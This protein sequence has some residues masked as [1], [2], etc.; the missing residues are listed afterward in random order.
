MCI[1]LYVLDKAT[2]IYVLSMKLVV[3][4]V[5]SN[6]KWCNQIIDKV[7]NI[8]CSDLF[9]L[10]VLKDFGSTEVLVMFIMP[11]FQAT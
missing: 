9:M 1:I 7:A 11:T 8:F 4:I 3:I 5:Q 6:G 2:I 10:M